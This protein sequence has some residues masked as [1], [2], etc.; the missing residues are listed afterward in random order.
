[1][2]PPG[3]GERV[4][5]KPSPASTSAAV[6]RPQALFVCAVAVFAV[7]AHAI[8]TVATIAE[9]TKHSAFPFGVMAFSF[10][11]S[12]IIRR[13]RKLIPNT[14]WVNTQAP[15]RG[16]LPSILLRRREHAGEEVG[17]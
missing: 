6:S 14:H 11:P 1:M 17:G 2:H 15:F 16:A 7:P 5:L 9:R 10:H 8:R 3:L 12:G 13:N 4:D